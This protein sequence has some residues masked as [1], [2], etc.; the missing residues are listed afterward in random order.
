MSI[1]RTRSIR[2]I[3]RVNSLD[4][5]HG[6]SNKYLSAVV[7]DSDIYLMRV[8]NASRAR[9]VHFP[10]ALRSSSN[11]SRRVV[12]RNPYGYRINVLVCCLSKP[13]SA[14]RWKERGAINN[15]H[16]NQRESLGQ[17]RA[18]ARTIFAT[19]TRGFA[20]DFQIFLRQRE[21]VFHAFTRVLR[22]KF[23]RTIVSA[24]SIAVDN[25]QFPRELL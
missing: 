2:K 22:R 11:R 1:I 18:L 25:M 23:N 4:V 3:H 12:L 7:C 19:Y 9:R 16:G 10:C 20:E 13:Y 6:L 14:S 24:L 15:F 5:S 21:C 8:V 17:G